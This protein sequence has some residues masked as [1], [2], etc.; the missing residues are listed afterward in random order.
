MSLP[1]TEQHRVKKLFGAFIEKR[2]PQHVRDQ[3]RLI[4]KITGR[5]VI[6]IETR[7]H[8]QDPTVWTEMPIAQ[9]E[10]DE[11]A[12]VWSLYAYDRNDKR[13]PYSKGHLELLIQEVDNDPTCIF[14][15]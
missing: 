1:E 14:W 3:V 2:V 4:Y 11:A 9:F 7:P 10:Y 15:G 8:F 6:L 13:K 12:K 5:K